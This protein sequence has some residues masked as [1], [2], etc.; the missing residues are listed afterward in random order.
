MSLN[1]HL[2]F[3]AFMEIRL[4]RAGQLGQVSWGRSAGAGQLGQ[5]SWGRSAGA[6][7]LG[8]AAN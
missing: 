7:Q 5:V 3:V 2:E 4:H 8:Q 6:G 1:C